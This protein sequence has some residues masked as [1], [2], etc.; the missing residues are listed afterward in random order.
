MYAADCKKVKEHFPLRR[1]KNKIAKSLIDK[2][3]ISTYL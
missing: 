2:S 1:K 3:L